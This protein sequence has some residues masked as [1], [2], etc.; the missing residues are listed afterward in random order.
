M[1]STMV[2]CQNPWTKSM[3]VYQKVSTINHMSISIDL[4]LYLLRHMSKS[5]NKICVS[6]PEVKYHKPCVNIHRFIVLSSSAYV[7][8]SMNKIYVGLPEGKYHKP[9]VN[10]HRFIALSSST[11]VKKSMN[12]IYVLLPEGKYHKPYVN[13]HRFIVLSSST[14]VK[15][16]EQ[17]LC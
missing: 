8:K 17:N 7:K 1:G 9:Y 10:I 15:I 16:H 12:K 2:I 5:M 14:Y 11:Y 3:L 4:S 13:I 6:L